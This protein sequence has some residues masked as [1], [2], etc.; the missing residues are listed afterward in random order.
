MRSKISIIILLFAAITFYGQ[1]ND[2]NDVERKMYTAIR[3]DQAP[4]I[5]GIP[6]EEVWKNAPV[7][8]FAYPSVRFG[9]WRCF[10]T[11]TR[12]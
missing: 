7:A 4:K 6:D 2:N 10:S 12:S 8:V 3:I 5:D 9:P 11:M 1:Q